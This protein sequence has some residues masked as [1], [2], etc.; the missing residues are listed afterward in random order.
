[1]SSFFKF[2]SKLDTAEEKST[3]NLEDRSI[4][5]T[6]TET[7]RAKRVEK[8]LTSWKRQEKTNAGMDVKKRTLVHCRSDCK[9]VQ[10][11]TALVTRR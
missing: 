11:F 8:K 10:L 4:E 9:L 2:I 5:I 3:N 6:Q 7:Q 1:M